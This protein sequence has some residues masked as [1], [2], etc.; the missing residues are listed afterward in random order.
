MSSKLLPAARSQWGCRLSD[1]TWKGLIV[2][3]AMQFGFTIVTFI[4]PLIL[5]FSPQEVSRVWLCFLF[6]CTTWNG[7][8]FYIEVG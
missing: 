7:A 5:V 1:L 2:F 4:F 6:C 8:S 3:C